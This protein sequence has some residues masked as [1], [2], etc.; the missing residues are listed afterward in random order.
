[1]RTDQNNHAKFFVPEVI[2]TSE[3][4]CGPAS[5]KALLEGF[6]VYTSYGRLRE[7]CH[8]SVDGTSI[9][10][11]EDLA[12]KLGLD[13][14]QIMLPYDHVLLEGMDALPALIVTK[15]PNGL[16]HFVVAWNRHGPWVQVM[17]PGIGR[18]WI[19]RDRF[20][21][22]IFKHTFPISIETWREWAGTDGF[23]NP[24]RKRMNL[25][26]VPE[27]QINEMVQRAVNDPR[28]ISLATLDA[29]IRLAA[30]LEKTNAISKGTQAAS[31][32]RQLF[33]SGQET[34]Q[35]PTGDEKKPD[36]DVFQIPPAYWSVAPVVDNDG[37][38]VQ[39]NLYGAVLIRVYGRTAK[40]E[41]LATGTE[42][43]IP[44]DLAS[45]L[46]EP[47]INVEKR[48]LA[49]IL[50]DGRGLPFLLVLSLI[51]TALGTTL[52]AGLMQV[53]LQINTILPEIN[54]RVLG[55]A[56]LLVFLL[57]LFLLELPVGAAIQSIGR[58]L[59]TR[60]RITFLEKLPL[61]NDRYFNSRLTSDM[62]T[63]ANGLRSLSS[64][65]SLIAQFIMSALR[66]IFTA[67][68]IIWLQPS[69]A[70]KAIGA[71]LIF[72]AIGWFS[73][74][75]LEENDMRQR[76]HAGALSRFYLEAM[77]GL[78]PLR[79]HS[80]ERAFRREHEGLLV[81]WMRSDNLFARTGII[82]QGVSA[83][84]YTMFS[85]WMG[86]D[87]IRQGGLE[88]GGMLLFYWTLNLPIYG[89]AIISSFQQ[90]PA[91]RNSLLRILEPLN[92]PEE[93]VE[94]AGTP[95]DVDA[96]NMQTGSAEPSAVQ[97]IDI[98]FKDLDIVAG[99]QPILRGINLK[100]NPGEH[101]AIVGPSGA[102][103]STLAG[104]LLGW[105]KPAAGE[106]LVDS[107]PLMDEVLMKLRRQT[108]WVDPEVQIWNRSLLEN[109]IYGNDLQE[110]GAR[111]LIFEE[112]DLT[113]LFE[114]LE[115][116]LQT[117]LGEG[118]GLVSGGEGQRVRLA[119]GMNRSGV[120]LVILDEPFR[121]LDHSQRRHLLE[122]ARKFWQNATLICITH[123]VDETLDFNRVL[124]IE[125]GQLI[126]DAA[127]ACLKADRGSRYHSM[128]KAE[129]QVRTGM[130]GAS[131]W[132]R[133]W[134][135]NGKLTEK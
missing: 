15:N 61:L 106:C 10:S 12:V 71:I 29:S 131:Q 68:G 107:A 77:Q 79:T 120:R 109:L 75:I 27:D 37:K 1:M 36:N 30:S 92:A 132:R 113:A 41:E 134:M 42:E 86:F 128:L 124:V 39:L 43:E 96:G 35:H 74:A 80:A 104:I 31:L 89:Q 26:D 46:T 103:K 130:W 3:M 69:S 101:I 23:L 49:D 129:E 21:D 50:K 117:N 84:L 6:G 105:H 90:Y 11:I 115:N 58:R 78:L 98:E 110:I 81:E 5:L 24:L 4:D 95:S 111:G 94:R 121:G 38:V 72:S 33:L 48:I 73:Q 47:P 65:P 22:D 55:M 126:E 44:E 13:A 93:T 67:A 32:I 18:R 14:E 16:T 19:T 83:L 135:E 118:G 133:L 62:I 70:L 28:W 64:L 114:R 2:Q 116:G 60:F 34:F 100:I 51:I 97:G 57:S 127:P 76:V 52:Q 56:V 17:D 9:D 59:E 8:T 112:A 53:L 7:A 102:G 88:T 85:T 123:D 87:Y 20:I 122:K 25:L 66:L 119:R 82:I 40:E 63:R 125:N 45:I 108:V 54:Q 99:G 91:I